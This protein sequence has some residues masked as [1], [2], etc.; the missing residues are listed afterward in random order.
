MTKIK[1][2]P[3]DPTNRSLAVLEALYLSHTRIESILTHK[4]THNREFTVTRRDHS[5]PPPMKEDSRR[6]PRM[7]PYTQRPSPRRV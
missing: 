7:D 3:V 1:R 2:M 4:D 5:Q 6:T